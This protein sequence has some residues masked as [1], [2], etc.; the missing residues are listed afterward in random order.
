MFMMMIDGDDGVS[1]GEL[2]MAL[3]I[4]IVTQASEYDD[5]V[6]HDVDIMMLTILTTSMIMILI[7]MISKSTQETRGEVQGLQLLQTGGRGQLP[8]PDIFRFAFKDWQR[9]MFFPI[10]E[11]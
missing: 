1:A 8:L 4:N 2:V 3:M 10:I 6:V 7:M 9:Y 11:G 5:V